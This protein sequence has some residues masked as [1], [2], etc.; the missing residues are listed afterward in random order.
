MFKELGDAQNYCSQD[1]ACKG[2]LGGNGTY[3]VT[4]ANPI[5]NNV[6]NGSFYR[7]PGAKVK[8]L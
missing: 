5:V 6:A 8:L 7:K 1:P 2:I 4:R 3:Q